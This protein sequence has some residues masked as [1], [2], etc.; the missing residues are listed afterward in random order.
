MKKLRIGQ[1]VY[2]KNVGFPFNRTDDGGES[3]E[4]ACCR[5]IGLNAGAC[6]NMVDVEP[7]IPIKTSTG[8]MSRCLFWPEQVVPEDRPWLV[9]HLKDILKLKK[10]LKQAALVAG[11]IE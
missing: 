7:I 2:T 4:G 9:K 8:L 11:D 1:C 10:V 5:V 3:W 6:K